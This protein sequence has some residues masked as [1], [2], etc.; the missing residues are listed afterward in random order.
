MLKIILQCPRYLAPFNERARDLRI[1]NQP[2]WLH[3]R[4]L[5]AGITTNEMELPPGARLPQVHEPCLVYRD[6]LFFDAEFLNAFLTAARKR[7]A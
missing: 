3:Q 2:L 6:H 1:Q 5:L 7:Q 4:D